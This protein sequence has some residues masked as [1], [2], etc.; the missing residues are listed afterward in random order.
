MRRSW[1]RLP[2]LDPLRLVFWAPM[3]AAGLG[4][5]ILY[6]RGI[7]SPFYVGVLVAAIVFDLLG[8]FGPTWLRARLREQFPV[9]YLLLLLSAWAASFYVLPGHPATPMVRLAALMHTTTLYV[10]LFLRRRPLVAAWH[11]LVTLG[12]FLA[13]VLPYSLQSYGRGG[14][15]DGPMLPLTLLLTHGTLILTLRS[16]A[17]ARFALAEARVR[18]QALHELAHHDPLTGLPNRRALEQ[19]LAGPPT[20]SVLAV[21]DVD[22]LKRVNDTLGHAAGDD[23]L[24]RFAHGFARAVGPG[25]RA[26]R[27]SGDEFALLIPGP[28]IP[29]LEDLVG[30]VAGEVR[31][32]YP[33]ADASVGGAPWQAG[34][35]AS[36]WLA[37]ADRAMYRH[38][39]RERR[40]GQAD[41]RT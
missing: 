10:F 1:L 20:G 29:H 37:R 21:V 17:E 31:R 19:D 36:A 39:E 22:G 28:E 9:A 41:D 23:L 3:V 26:Y 12:A 27:I 25:G 35:C 14:A 32:T 8:L 16:F 30:T 15:F 6:G 38:K 11:A 34:E 7:P 4:L 33:Q 18:A 5:I 2:P 40:S 13:V 24:R